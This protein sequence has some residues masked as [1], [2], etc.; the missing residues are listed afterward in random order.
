MKAGDPS[1]PKQRAT[2]NRQRIER[3]QPGPH[4]ADCFHSA[5]PSMESGR[6]KLRRAVRLHSDHAPNTDFWIWTYA[7][8]A[9]GI[10]DVSPKYRSNGANNPPTQDQFKTYT[11]G[12]NTGAWQTISMTKR[13]VAPV[14]GLSAYGNGPQF[15][16]DYYYAKVTG[17][18][19]YVRRLLCHGERHQGQRLQF[20]DPTCLCRAKRES[21]PTPTP[22]TDADT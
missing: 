7:Y 16:A 4:R 12:A 9:S 17:L 21:T 5:A 2:G 13:V 6:K 19:G 11:G 14:A 18:F 22:H 20:P 10:Q 3:P 1:S 8:G 15:I